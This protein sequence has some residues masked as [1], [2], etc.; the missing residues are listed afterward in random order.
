M[1]ISYRR[2]GD[3]DAGAVARLHA[4]SWRR[5]YRGIYP[6]AYLD[7][8]LLGDRSVL[9]NERLR[10]GNPRRILILAESAAALTGFVC[11]YGAEDAAWGSLID[12][13]HVARNQQRTGVGRALMRAAAVALAGGYGELPVH[14]FALEKNTNARGFYD[15]LG[16][17]NAGV[18]PHE[19]PGGGTTNACRYAWDSPAALI[20]ACDM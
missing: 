5:T 19:T 8:D 17:R 15:R 20:V 2:G 9:W 13:L 10:D 7:G 6:D 1:D 16:G 12:N 3:P 4:E 11:I 18:E 14:L